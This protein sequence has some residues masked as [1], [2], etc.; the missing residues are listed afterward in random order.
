MSFNKGEIHLRLKYG[1]VVMDS[2]STSYRFKRL[3]I[4][5]NSVYIM[6]NSIINQEVLKIMHSDYFQLLKKG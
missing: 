4:Y 1:I 5:K 6:D 2:L 3:D